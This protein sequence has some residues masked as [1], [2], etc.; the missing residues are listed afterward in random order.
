MPRQHQSSTA[1]R[2]SLLLA[3]VAALLGGAPGPV[4]ADDGAVL[5]EAWRRTERLG[6]YAFETQLKQTTTPAPSIAA[7]GRRA[8]VTTL[9]MDGRADRQAKALHLTLWS[10]PTGVRGPAEG[11]EVRIEGVTASARVDGGQWRDF[12]GLDGAFAPSGDAAAF[13]A[14]AK[15]VRLLGAETRTVPTAAGGTRAVTFRR[16]AF[17]LDG[18]AYAAFL[19]DLATEYLQSRGEL[20]A[21]MRLGTADRFRNVASR[22][23]AWI[24]AGGLPLRMTLALEHPQARDGTRTRVEIQT[25]FK[26]YG[27]AA[28]ASASGPFWSHPLEWVAAHVPIGGAATIGLAADAALFAL[29]LAAGYAL[30]TLRRRRPRLAYR[31]VAT[32]MVAQLTLMPLVQTALTTRQVGRFME[33]FAPARIA[34]AA[35]AETPAATA[36]WTAKTAGTP[37]FANPLKARIDGAA[38]SVAPPAQAP[39][40]PI[41]DR[42]GDGLSAALERSWGTS[43]TDPDHDNDG[44]SDYDETIL[45]P[46][47]TPSD[48]WTATERAA[49]AAASGCPNPTQRDTDGDTLT[50]GEEA[51]HIGTAPN[52]VDTDSDGIGDPTEIRGYALGAGGRGYPD[53]RNPDSDGDGLTDGIECPTMRDVPEPPDP[54][55]SSWTPTLACVDSGVQD[56]PDVDNA[57]ND[58]DGVPN[59]FDTSPFVGST[60]VFDDANPLQLE[61]AGLQIGKPV[62]VDIQ[63]R[64]TKPRQLSFA[65]NVLDWPTGDNQGQIQRRLD[66]T[67]GDMHPVDPATPG[68]NPDPSDPAFGGD[69]RVS[70]MLEI[71]LPADS[72]E[73]P[74]R[75]AKARVTI[76]DAGE[77][78][79]RV[80]FGNKLKDKRTIESAQATIEALIGPAAT[81]TVAKGRCSATG[82]AAGSTVAT[83]GVNLSDAK[84][85]PL[86]AFADLGYLA[87]G[88]HVAVLEVGAVP[89]CAP[90]PSLI[91]G[92]TAVS[93][94]FQRNTPAQVHEIAT[95]D[96]AQQGPTRTDLA[97][98]FADPTRRYDVRIRDGRCGQLGAENLLISGLQG[99]VTRTLGGTNAVDL[100][101]G[102]H[103]ITVHEGTKTVGCAPLGNIVSGFSGGSNQIDMVDAAALQPYQ[104]TVHE[105]GDGKLVAIAP[106]LRTI[107]SQTGEPVAFNASMLYRLSA[108][109]TLRHQVR[110]LWLVS[111]VNDDGAL[112]VVHQYRS[113]PWR[114]T[115]VGLREE[116]GIDVAVAYEDPVVDARVQL[117]ADPETAQ[118]LEVEDDLWA[119]ANGLEGTF[120]GNRTNAAGART[121]TVAEIARR[122]ERQPAD[123]TDTE[124]WNI[125]PDT[126]NVRTF[127]YDGSAGL[128]A[129]GAT[130]I[131]SLLQ[132]EFGQGARDVPDLAGN[133]RTTL[134]PTLLL[135]MESRSRSL[136][137]D[138][139]APDGDVPALASLSGATVALNLD[140]A[141]VEAATTASLS[142]KP[143]RFDV[144]VGGWTM[145]PLEEYWRRMEK[146]LTPLK[147]FQDQAARGAEGRYETAADIAIAQVAYSRLFAGV[148]RTVQIGNVTLKSVATPEDDELARIGELSAL[149]KDEI[150]DRVIDF[151]IKTSQPFIEEYKEHK[152]RNRINSFVGLKAEPYSFRGAIGRMKLGETT[153]EAVKDAVGSFAEDSFSGWKQRL[154]T[155]GA[156]GLRAATVM[157]T[158]IGSFV[159]AEVDPE[160]GVTPEN[161]VGL[162]L[163]GI[164]AADTIVEFYRIH[165][166]FKAFKLE[167]P[168]S[169]TFKAFLREVDASSSA[170][171]SAVAGWVVGTGLSF[172]LFFEGVA[173]SGIEVG[174]AEYNDGIVDIVAESLLD[175]VLAALA[176]TGY[177]SVAVAIIALIDGLV[178]I[179]C[180]AAPPDEDDVIA[181]GACM[182]IQGLLAEAI[183]TAIYDETD[184][185]DLSN[186]NR[187][188]FRR[189]SPY[190]DDP[191]KAFVPDATLKVELTVRNTITRTEPYGIGQQY[192]HQLDE[193]Q[194]KESAF[195]YAITTD[196]EPASMPSVKL[197]D[198]TDWSVTDRVLHVDRDVAGAPKLANE[199]GIN[200]PVKAWLAEAYE[201][202]VQQCAGLG[203]AAC[204][205]KTRSDDQFIDL[206]LAFDVFPATLDAF[207]ALAPKGPPD[208]GG[209]A[210]A[211]GQTGPLTF[212]VL[213]DA[214]GDGLHRSFDPDDGRPDVDGDGVPD[215]REKQLGS[216]PLR[217]D[218]D[219]DRLDDATELRRDTD[220]LLA[221]TDGDGLAD[222]AEL[223]GWPIAYNTKGD[224]TWV[225]P[226]PRKRDAE[227]DGIPDGREAALGFSPWAV[228]DGRVLNYTTELREP[229]AP[230]ILI[231]FDEPGGAT[232]VPDTAQP[233]S[234]FGGY[235]T[236]PS[237]PVTGHSAQ[238]GNSA[239][240]DGVDDHFSLGAVPEISALSGDFIVSAWIMPARVTGRQR[241]VGLSRDTRPDGFGFGLVDDG[242]ILTYYGVEDYIAPG[243]GIPVDEWTWV[244][245]SAERVVSPGSG[246]LSTRVH[247]LALRLAGND[248]VGS[249][250]VVTSPTDGA[251]PDQGEALMIGAV[252]APNASPGTTPPR[253]TEAFAGR[254]DEVV[255]VREPLRAGDDVEVRLRSQMLGVYNLDDGTVAPGQRIV[256]KTALTNRLLSKN[257]SGL[258][259][260]D[261]PAILRSDAPAYQS[262]ALGPAVEGAP[263]PAEQRILHPMAVSE[264]AASGTYDVAQD[265]AATIDRRTVPLGNLED[266]DFVRSILYDLDRAFVLNANTR[267]PNNRPVSAEGARYDGGD[268]TVAAWV[269]WWAQSWAGTTPGVRH[270]IMGHEAGRDLPGAGSQFLPKSLNGMSRGAFPSLLVEDGH[271]VFGFGCTDPD[272]GWCE[273][274]SSRAY[275]DKK[276][277]VHVAISYN[278]ATQRAKLYINQE[279][280]EDLD[281]TG[282]VPLGARGFQVG[283]ANAYNYAILPLRNDCATGRG[284]YTIAVSTDDPSEPPTEWRLEQLGPPGSTTLLSPVRFHSRLKVELVGGKQAAGLEYLSIIDAYQDLQGNYIDPTKTISADGCASIDLRRHSV[285]PFSGRIWDLEVYGRALNQAQ[286]TDLVAS[287]STIAR[288]KLDEVP[289][290]TRFEDYV[291]G[292]SG[293]CAGDGCPTVGLRGR[294]NLAAAFDGVDDRITDAN[295]G[296][297]LASYLQTPTDTGYSFG[298]WVRPGPAQR[299]GAFLSG[300]FLDIAPAELR[301]VPVAGKPDKVRF[302]FGQGH[303]D[304]AWS[305]PANEYARDAWHHVLVAVDTRQ[306]TS[307]GQLYVDGSPVGGAFEGSLPGLGWTIGGANGGAR[308]YE[309]LVDDV[310]IG[311]GWLDAAGVRALMDSVPFHALTMDDPRPQ[312]L[313][314]NAELAVG[315]IN[316]SRQFVDPSD[317]VIIGAADQFHMYSGDFTFAAWVL[318]DALGGAAGDNVYRPIVTANDATRNP[319]FGLFNGRPYAYVETAGKTNTVVAD[320]DIP[321]NQ[322]THVVFRRKSD[323]LRDNAEVLTIFVNGSP[324]KQAAGLPKV[325]SPAGPPQVVVGGSPN[326]SWRGR[327]DEVTF[328][329]SA[330]NDED[331]AR[332]F[333]FQNTWIDERSAAPLTVDGLPPSA[334]FA[335][336]GEYIPLGQPSTFA[337]DT[338]DLHSSAQLAVLELKRPGRNVSYAWGLPCRDAVDGSAMC[339]AFDPPAE[340]RYDVTVN[341]IDAVGNVKDYKSAAGGPLHVIADGTAPVV[342][343]A[344][345]PATPFRPTHD[346]ADPTRWTLPLAGTVADPPIG[347]DPGSGVAG[348]DVTI[349]D[350]NGVPLGEPPL[351]QADVVDG[352]W[353]LAYV[354]RGDQPTGTFGGEVTAVDRVGKATVLTVPPFHLDATSPAARLTGIRRTGGA[355]VAVLS[356]PPDAAQ[357]AHLASGSPRPDGAVAEAIAQ[358]EP[359][360]EAYIGLTSQIQGTVDER[361][362]TVEA[363]DA[364]A[365]VAR[366]QLAA[367]PLFP[368]SAPFINQAPPA[369]ALLYLPFDKS[370]VVGEAAAQSYTDLVMGRSA[371]CSTPN[372]PQAGTTGR[373]GQALR[374]DGIDDGLALVHDPAIGAL[375][376]DFTVAAWIKPD[377]SGGVQRI[378][379]SPRT[380]NAEGWS[381]GLSGS[382]LRLTSWYIQD[383]NSAPGVVTP[384][385]WQHVAVHLSAD[386]DAEFYVNG[387]HVETVAGDLPA[388]A[389]ADSPLLIG[390]AS[391]TAERSTRDPF[392]GLI[393]DV[394]VARGRLAAADWPTLLG[395]GPTLHLGFDEQN[396][397]AGAALADAGGMGTMAVYHT[398]DRADATNH[399][400]V[401]VVGSGALDLTPASDGFLVQTPLGV[402]PAEGESY[403]LALWIEDLNQ[404]QLAYGANT[405]RFDGSGLTPVIHG[406]PYPASARDP[407]GWHHYAIVWDAAAGALSTYQDGALLRTDAIAG[408][409]GIGAEPTELRFTHLSQ[410]ARY[411]LDDLRLYRR[412]L[413]PLELAALAATRWADAPVAGLGPG[414]TAGATWSAMLPPGLEGYHDVKVRGIDAAGNLDAEPR[415]Q[416]SGIIDTLAP[417][418]LGGFAQPDESGITFELR[419]EDFSLDPARLALPG[420]C[421]RDLRID[422]TAYR[423][424]W[425]LALAEQL[426]DE[427]A[428]RLRARTYGATITCRARY[429]VA[430]ETM[431]ICDHAG[432]CQVVVYNGPSIGSPPPTA[433]P[434]AT[435]TPTSPPA[436]S[437][438]ATGPAQATATATRRPGSPT[439]GIPTATSPGPRPTSAGAT[440]TP[441][442]TKGPAPG[443]GVRIFL[444]WLVAPRAL[445]PPPPSSAPPPT[446]PPSPASPTAG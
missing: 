317:R 399:A 181:T 7:A 150:G 308:P 49:N 326:S 38:D 81:L 315:Q 26:G 409:S 71:T 387:R 56:A 363:Q 204:W 239:L 173:R 64:P 413:P 440:V 68:L 257:V 401:G 176:L 99:H 269:N 383:Y 3:V 201:I 101:D 242:L 206:G 391:L 109:A 96:V 125:A 400:R 280:K 278:R 296:L 179:I 403:T 157:A 153:D 197:G 378:V 379:S 27:S 8:K 396:V 90:I 166:A 285:T 1:V 6:R 407:A 46:V 203:V 373:N 244:A 144:T 205:V 132:A 354:L 352:G 432:N 51:L 193:G 10:N 289:G 198:T 292:S 404:G 259:K 185:V 433:T 414:A 307:K 214:D 117:D 167:N 79:G 334:A 274:K 356:E 102:R 148:A 105:N 405:V 169:P 319:Y 312:V 77:V 199:T 419:F 313:N 258:L 416:W 62:V 138:A 281:L 168:A 361:P 155:R 118:H 333:N 321:P 374:F 24:D 370:G 130:E 303:D 338:H 115:G 342:T 247:F 65:Q 340:G 270:G 195:A 106:L 431:S 291:G 85:L 377:G 267:D 164:Q 40:E 444:P 107:D 152:R 223:A 103:V 344:P 142:W 59:R 427:A 189:F 133:P 202:N 288:Y 229:T 350:A 200:R 110:V 135:A 104:I 73:L 186:P 11:L 89:Y 311:K 37:A 12:D 160:V 302:W 112:Q 375:T 119:L 111:M 295:A 154:A 266:K 161:V 261:V 294:E 220:P 78:V 299:T 382:R 218:T 366:V 122:W 369:N 402:L 95:L 236:A 66:N 48:P 435:P 421:A 446:P 408:G 275:I 63:L 34:H 69:M 437:P 211:W 108:S 364:Y 145:Y 442:A 171:V 365:G 178:T 213:A 84:R 372:C 253:V 156:N 28:A 120:V 395:L 88:Q 61:I 254:I 351:Q 194:A 418:F 72:T 20:P 80:V 52:S 228:N 35:E 371:A 30:L 233:N 216:D 410:T 47:S 113:E 215:L 18:A 277:D 31:L 251:T 45:C 2:S 13:L 360:D 217:V 5:R 357:P 287:T 324:V 235:C 325:P 114:L 428:A 392:A 165:Q 343:L 425:H 306:P 304:K 301:A 16:Y 162:T 93:V 298:A 54:Y 362:Q 359:A 231:R 227:G 397:V 219:G 310:F 335:Q 126:L 268:I 53:A 207:Y 192:P 367:E 225:F 67:I 58:G 44:I 129:L 221:D 332:L 309:G 14:A 42:D 380:D 327:L 33:R 188:T 159:N 57:D 23:E 272:N 75:S 256:H 264:D 245:A 284:N 260:V 368:H 32:V 283:S 300:H 184:V 353:R 94:A 238:M 389:D 384:G 376:N 25:D 349:R 329:R 429:V 240:F 314:W 15:N 415:S 196:Q 158:L 386:N 348:V 318:G 320:H 208:E 290:Q 212:P 86:A 83:G 412:A 4:H 337:V 430:N 417:R 398:F 123:Y 336:S 190:L 345:L 100:V 339:P 92:E 422:E 282:M 137:L 276:A 423:S 209:R 146:V 438:T 21:G 136:N 140:P 191:V 127:R 76:D 143:Y 234:P 82:S 121:M 439:V 441:E 55:A 323:P 232:T 97:F 149:A 246:E 255:I 263:A 436:S 381:F 19:R 445:T 331:I 151:L 358:Q 224:K 249:E 187:L 29:L 172:G 9:F 41:V 139:A 39:A 279:L 316:E 286:I 426:P 328:Y 141:R 36:A 87:N 248:V 252:H 222:D 341:A 241:I 394:V 434:G 322:W 273:V 297:L 147:A 131:P 22:G 17:A 406:S 174:G 183:A 390:T 265:M 250:K 443:Q 50:D 70:P 293:S 388:T 116:Q 98:A 243:M 230:S 43:D 347:A 175:G 74:R 330:L 393:D 271:I 177:G 411:G 180:S 128:G 91:E 134:V 385:I 163:Q 210:L 170:R 124:R 355:R 182:G 226:A 424:P 346:A 237:C 262:F 420:D 60:T 305:F